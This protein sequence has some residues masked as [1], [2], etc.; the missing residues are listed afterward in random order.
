MK[1]FEALAKTVEEAIELGLQELGVS[2]GD[3]D[4]LVVE[5]GSKGLFGL[6]GSRPAKV[7]LTVKASEEDPLRP[8]R[9]LKRKL[10][11]R[12]RDRKR[13]MRSRRLRASPL[14]RRRRRRNRRRR[15]R[16]QKTKPLP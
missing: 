10:R 9:A 2:I 11:N 12:K 6:F 7:R 15:S 16:K 14:P 4:V 5:E 1:Q 3:V 13:R 8:K